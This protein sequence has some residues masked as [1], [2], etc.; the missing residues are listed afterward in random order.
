MLSAYNKSLF[1]R[2][3]QT[4]QTLYINLLSN[5]LPDE[6]DPTYQSLLSQLPDYQTSLDA[7]Y[8]PVCA[9]CIGGVE[10][11]IRKSERR[12]RADALGGWLR[13]GQQYSSPKRTDRTPPPRTESSKDIFVWW[14]RGSLWVLNL[15]V[16]IGLSSLGLLNLYVRMEN[17]FAD[18]VILAMSPLHPNISVPRPLIYGLPILCLI[19][20]LWTFWDPTWL[21][22]HRAMIKAIDLRV[23][24]RK[25]W[26][27]SLN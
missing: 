23:T 3:C 9:D 17:N 15:V 14:I 18:L 25:A 11:E 22:R 7:R 10:E 21:R 13:D 20:V 24:G 6:K 12:A 2:T 1:C 26:I 4:N 16:S 19:S 8:P 5:Y 27:V